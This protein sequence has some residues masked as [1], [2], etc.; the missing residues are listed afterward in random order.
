[1]DNVKNLARDYDVLIFDFD[2]VVLDSNSV[3]EQAFKVLFSAYPPEIQDQVVAY[4]RQNLGVPRAAKIRY[5]YESLLGESISDQSVQSLCQV[6]SD[7]TLERLSQSEIAIADTIGFIRK[8]HKHKKLFIASAADQNDVVK[9]CES[10]DLT[11]YFIGVFGSPTAKKDIVASIKRL[12]P[13]FKCALIG[14]SI[15][16]Y[17]AA[18]ENS[19]DF[20]GYNNSE[21]KD[22]AEYVDRFDS[23][24]I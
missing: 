23:L 3:K 11:D 7:K 20:W 5:Y 9:L 21:L 2:G 13:G 17:Y 8:I 16:D 6:F 22:V 1:M 18:R 10:H 15:H 19:V 24:D 14:D 4:H 12:Y